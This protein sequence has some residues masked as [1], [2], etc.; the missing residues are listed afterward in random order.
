MRPPPHPSPV[1]GQELRLWSPSAWNPI[2]HC[3]SL[4]SDLPHSLGLGAVVCK[5]G[6]IM[7]P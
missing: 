2:H 3:T 1:G 6:I 5:V 7:A 4:L